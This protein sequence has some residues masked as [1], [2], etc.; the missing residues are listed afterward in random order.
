LVASASTASGRVVAWKRGSVSPRAIACSWSFAIASPFS[1]WTST[2]S[3][4][5]RAICMASKRSSSSV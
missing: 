3:P 2:S 5:S 4:H 1:A